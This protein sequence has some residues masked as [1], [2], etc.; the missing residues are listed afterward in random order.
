MIGTLWTANDH[1]IATNEGRKQF[2]EACIGNEHIDFEGG[3]YAAPDHNQYDAYKKL[4]LPTFYPIDEYLKKTHQSRVVFN[5]PAVHN[6]HGWKLAEY[7]ALGKAIISTPLS[8]ELP[9]ELE[10]GKEIH[11][12]HDHSEIPSALQELISNEKYNQSLQRNARDYFRKYMTPKSVVAK[13]VGVTLNDINL[14]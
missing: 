13:I 7:L 12:I 3:F 5:T 2:V 1:A 9:C 6:C 4:L 8:N 14:S 10:H 11:I